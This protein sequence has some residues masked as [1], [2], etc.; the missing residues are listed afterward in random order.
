VA[1]SN[2]IQALGGRARGAL[3][4]RVQARAGTERAMRFPPFDGELDRSLQ[5]NADYARL[6]GFALALNRLHEERI[7][8]AVAEVGV[9]RGD[10]SVVLQAAAPSRDLHLFD[11]FEGFPQEQLDV[12]GADERF[13]DTSAA[14]VRARLPGGALV[15]IHAG[16]VPDTLAEVAEVGFAF[17][18]LDM[19]IS[20]PT[21]AS[22]EFFYPRLASGGFVFVHDYNSPES[23]HAGCRSLD[24]FLADR[25]ERLVELADPWGSA[26]FRKH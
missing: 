17:V 25:P 26:L 23:D 12:P 15:H 9:W 22:L 6:A 2:P 14:A 7:E 19:D 13:R 1:R 3:A 20:A 5:A 4:A 11:T 10:A 21:I 18:L 24:G 8:G 16:V